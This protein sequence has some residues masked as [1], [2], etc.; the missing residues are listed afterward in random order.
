[1]IIFWIDTIE[2]IKLDA[3]QTTHASYMF[4]HVYTCFHIFLHVFMCSHIFSRVFTLF[5][6]F[7][8]SFKGFASFKD[9]KWVT[10]LLGESEWP[11]QPSKFPAAECTTCFHWA[12]TA[13]P[14]C[15]LLLVNA[16]CFWLLMPEC[17]LTS[18]KAHFFSM[19]PTS[20]GWKLL[21]A[22]FKETICC[23]IKAE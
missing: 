20:A 5:H 4:S 16:H 1:M 13:S 19:H 12:H 17:L 8:Q 21:N 10:M 15:T 14:Q 18:S 11:S 23:L 2:S 3:T 7:S 9:G 22:E 6:M